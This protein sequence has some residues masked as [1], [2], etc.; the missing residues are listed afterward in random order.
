MFVGMFPA[1][2]SGTDMNRLVFA[3]MM[4]AVATT[5]AL[6]EDSGVPLAS[7]GWSGFYVGGQISHTWGRS[8]GGAYFRATGMPDVFSDSIDPTGFAGGA[9]I[10]YNYQLSNSIV[11]GV[12]ADYNRANI[13]S[14]TV[15][16]SLPGNTVNAD[17][18]W[19]GSVRGRV[20]VAV[21]RFMP[22]VTAGYAFGKYEF[23]PDYGA[24][25]P[26]PG[27]KIHGGATVGAGVE[28][29]ITEK[30]STRLEYRYTDFGKARYDISGFP[31]EESRINLR[32]SDLRIGVTFKF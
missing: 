15:A 17:M 20:G 19:N 14:G 29:A 2:H 3:A 24:T 22:Y 4:A 27:S 32:T 8:T 5:S 16:L 26:L 18:P 10:G 1:P 30:V 13:A 23:T 9:Y 31:A 7:N 6:A 25:P 21:D 12:E 28:Y 11:L